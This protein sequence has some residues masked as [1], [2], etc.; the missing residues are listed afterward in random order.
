MELAGV[1]PIARIGDLDAHHVFWGAPLF[2]AGLIAWRIRPN[3]AQG[4]LLLAPFTI[5][6]LALV[7][8]NI[9]VQGSE[10]PL[11]GHPGWEFARTVHPQA[12]EGPALPESGLIFRA[13][14]GRFAKGVQLTIETGDHRRAL[15]PVLTRKLR[16]TLGARDRIGEFNLRYLQRRSEALRLLTLPPDATVGLAWAGVL[17]LI[18]FRRMPGIF[19]PIF[20]IVLT[21]TLL[22]ET[23]G[24]ERLPL[25]Y[26]GVIAA[27]G[28]LVSAAQSLRRGLG[29]AALFL[30]LYAGSLWLLAVD[31]HSRG[32]RY[33]MNEFIYATREFA[34][35]GEEERAIMERNDYYEIQ[36]MERI[37]NN[38]WVTQ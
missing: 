4:F 26:L 3:L 15:Q 33:R 37:I 36:R 14:E 19:P 25:H 31:D 6:T 24:M 38:F 13:A 28:A 27:G 18:L 2:V 35:M 34:R 11:V 30:A 9:S 1:R 7:M 16:E 8:R 22:F 5:L 23:S 29:P 10:T 12:V 17:F 21:H 20:A 32:S